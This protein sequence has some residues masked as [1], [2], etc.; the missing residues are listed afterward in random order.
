MGTTSMG[1]LVSAVLA[2]G[3]ILTCLL[4]VMA[5]LWKRVNWDFDFQG[6]LVFLTTNPLHK[7][8]SGQVVAKIG[9]LFRSEI[10]SITL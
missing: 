8:Q 10:I 6:I 4:L 7:W 2:A 9:I 5:I 1:F 3:M